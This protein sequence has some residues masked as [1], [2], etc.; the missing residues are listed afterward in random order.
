MPSPLSAQQ[1]FRAS[2]VASWLRSPAD[3][4]CELDESYDTHTSQRSRF[5][6]PTSTTKVTEGLARR[7]TNQCGGLLGGPEDHKQEPLGAVCISRTPNNGVWY[8][9]LKECPLHTTANLDARVCL[10]MAA[11][12]SKKAKQGDMQR[13]AR[14]EA[15]PLSQLI[16][17][18]LPFSSPD[19][20]NQSSSRDLLP[21][22]ASTPLPAHAPQPT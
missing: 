22:I 3:D 15:R 5:V 17:P 10:E 1:R 7:W 19:R 11:N 14:M 4:S 12:R 13:T 16:L 8:I 6:G 20:L 2:L 21:L 9:S 18:H